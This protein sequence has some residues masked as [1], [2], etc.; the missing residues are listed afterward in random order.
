[1]SEVERCESCGRRLKHTEGH[2]CLGC[3]H[4]VCNPCAE[5]APVGTHRLRSHKKKR[6][7]DV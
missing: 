1:M 6:E 3:H 7:V 4:Y 2:L 5:N